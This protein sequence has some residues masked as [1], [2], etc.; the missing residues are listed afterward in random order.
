[1]NDP[2]PYLDRLRPIHLFKGLDEAAILDLASRLEV[3]RF[4]ADDIIFNEGELGQHFF[5][6]HKGEVIIEREKPGGDLL[7]YTLAP[8]DYFGVP[9]LLYGRA[10]RATAMAQTKVIL[11]ALSKEHFDDLLYLYPEMRPNLLVSSESRELYARTDMDWL[12]EKEIVYL[13]TRRHPVILWQALALPV[14]LALGALVLV[15][16]AFIYVS[17]QFGVFVFLLAGV[18]LGGWTV[19]VWIDWG[20]DYYIVTNQRVVYLEKVIGIYDSRQEAPLT[21]VQSVKTETAGTLER[22]L[23][24]GDVLVQTFSGPIT[25]KAVANPKALA[26]LIEEQWNRSKTYQREAEIEQ[27]KKAVRQRIVNPSLDPFLQQQ[28][29][30]PTDKPPR[31]AGAPAPKRGVFGGGRPQTAGSATPGGPATP[32]SAKPPTPKSAYKITGEGFFSFKIRI[33]EGDT[34]IYRKHWYL[35]IQDILQPSLLIIACLGLLG[36]KLGGVLPEQV[37]WGVLAVIVGVGLL[38]LAGWWVYLFEDWKNDIYQITNDQI[39]A[40]HKKPLGEETRNAAPLGN[41]LNLRYERPGLIG[42]VLNYGT[43]VASVAGQDFRFDGVFDPRGV[44]NDIYRRMEQIT[45]RKAQTEA[46]KRRDELANWVSVYHA[47]TKEM[48]E[49]EERKRKGESGSEQ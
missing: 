48:E 30:L 12:G 35:L 4:Q 16:A 42:L 32:A 6:I 7:Q 20:N 21:S 25:L 23:G 9:A 3:V 18:G 15:I 40:L 43:V 24:L 29:Q 17:W 37:T 27:L 47:V 5:I 1:M 46:T 14:A 19:W 8:G 36:L 22:Q 33:E 13:I 39:I 31:P 49:E 34:I 11:L 26:A 44:Q 38:P 41:V 10:H 2:Q 45:Y 28:A